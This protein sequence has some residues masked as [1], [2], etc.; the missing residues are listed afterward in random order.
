MSYYL[1]APLAKPPSLD[2]TDSSGKI[3]AH[4]VG[5][6]VAGINRTTWDLGETGPVQWTSA[7]DWNKG[8]DDG[9][10]VLPGAYTVRLS[11]G[12][13]GL[14]RTFAVKPDP[15]AHWTQADYAA[16]HQIERELDDELSAID[17][18]L[19]AMDKHGLQDS[20]AY[21][22][23]TSHPINS[24]DDLAVPDGLRERIMTLIGTLGL[25]Q[26]PPSAAHLREAAAIRAQ[27]DAAMRL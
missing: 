7:R 20:D 26:G 11:L 1:R 2:F 9:P 6:N 19:N 24:E 10:T 23:L 17:V 22:A 18:K 3:V 8:P 15:R 5:T 13:R 4:V 12:G 25:S 21:R 16:R 27:F 14:S